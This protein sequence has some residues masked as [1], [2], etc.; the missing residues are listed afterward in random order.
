[1]TTTI[2]RTIMNGNIINNDD[3]IN[4]VKQRI[5]NICTV[6]DDVY[7]DITEIIQK[8]LDKDE[9]DN[10]QEGRNSLRK[11]ILKSKTELEWSTLIN[12]LVD[13][14]I[15]ADRGIQQRDIVIEEQDEEIQSLKQD[16]KSREIINNNLKKALET[17]NKI[18]YDREKE[19]EK[20]IVEALKL[21]KKYIKPR[22]ANEIMRKRFLNK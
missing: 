7:N 10:L 1:M 15:Y 17:L 19:R 5:K 12:F 11:L 21:T 18:S 8:E 22:K 4:A 9:R 13:R 14:M 2:V 6:S 3:F 20:E 16:L